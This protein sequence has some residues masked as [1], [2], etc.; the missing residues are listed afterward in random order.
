MT[1]K[2]HRDTSRNNNNNNHSPSFL[3]TLGDEYKAGATLGE[4]AL[5][6]SRSQSAISRWLGKLGVKRRPQGLSPHSPNSSRLT[7]EWFWCR[8]S[9]NDKDSCWNW[10]IKKR[11][12]YGI[13]QLYGIRWNGKL[14]SKMRSA[15]RH[16]WE[17]TY[18]RVPSGMLVCHKCD[19]PSCCNP[20]HL[21]LGTQAENMADASRKGRMRGSP[22]HD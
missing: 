17:L 22:K 1:H 5:R 8:V 6:H 19:N 4:L 15:H 2:P 12:G 16:A 21:W 9:K 7:P 14:Y 3:K 20:H 18:G 10:K 13:F 11:R